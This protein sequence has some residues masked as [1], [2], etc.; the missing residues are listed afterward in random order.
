MNRRT[1]ALA[2]TPRVKAAVFE[3]DGGVCIFCNRP[4]LPEA[5]YIPR[6]QGGLGIKENIITVCRECHD[7]LDNSTQRRGMLRYVRR[8]LNAIYPDFPDKKRRYDKYA[9]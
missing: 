5:R 7:L 8:Y 1:K 4:G 2:I 3:R 6:S 9:E